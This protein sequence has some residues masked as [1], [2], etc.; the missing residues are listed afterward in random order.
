M[1]YPNNFEEKLGFDRLREWLAS[2]CISLMGDEQAQKMQ[3]ETSLPVIQ[4]KLDLI[5]EFMKLMDNG[6]PFPVRDYSDLREELHHLRIEGTVISQEALFALKPNFNALKAVLRYAVSDAASRYPAFQRLCQGVSLDTELWK[7]CNRLTDDKGEIPDSASPELAAIR[8][9]IRQKL[10]TIDRQMNKLLQEAKN[11]G[12]ADSGVEATIRNGRMVIPVRAADKRKLKGFIHDESATGQ[13]VYI[14]PTAVFDTNNE[15]RELEYAEKREINRILATFT[16]L[17][18][19]YLSDLLA[20]WEL[21]GSIDLVRAK[22]ILAQHTQAGIPEIVDEP[23][24]AWKNARHPLLEKSLNEQQRKIVPLDLVLD[25]ETRILIISGPNAGGKSVC[26]KTAGLIQY[27][28]Q[29]GLAVPMDH[30]AVCGIF[31]KLFID[32]GDEQSLE[33]DLSTYSSHLLN[34][35]QFMAHA[36]AR[37]LFLIDEFGAGTEPQLGGAIAEAVLKTLNDKKAFGL[38]TTHYANLKLMADQQ[39]GVFNGAML[40]DTNKLEPLYMLQTG[41]PGSSFAFE[42]ARKIGFPEE[43][44][45]LAS[46]IT[47]QSHLDFD[48]QLQQLEVEKKALAKKQ[49]EVRLADQLLNEVIEKYKRLLKQVEDNKKNMLAEAGHEAKSLIDKA[50]RQ[51]EHTIKQIR[52]A[53]ADKE[54]TKVLRSQ[55]RD[56]RDLL[57]DEAQELAVKLQQAEE[58]EEEAHQASELKAGDMVRIEEM[59]ISGELLSISEHEAVISFNSVKLRTS[60]ERLVKLSRKDSRKERQQRKAGSSRSITTDLNEKATQFKL[61]N[62]LRGKRAAE[63]LDEVARYIDEAILLS[64]KEVNILHGKGDGILRK[65]IREF[66]SK[67]KEVAFFG[68]APP[69]TGGNGVTKVSLR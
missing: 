1:I 45:A 69:E 3:F 36:D 67:Q 2:Y 22:A 31:D 54:K 63:A 30:D 27:M 60:P 47:G 52:E 51:I 15:V 24:M 12:W 62:D 42:I 48:Q 25:E 11:A 39:E 61:T 50:N 20:G 29:C 57:G 32:I 65:L 46:G 5:E 66:L 8:R 26:L 16:G 17:M 14:E 19:P 41:K 43:I 59:D 4:E 56:T 38:V 6:L 21:L 55:L 37:S 53:Q 35:K 33:N 23:R 68:D 49:T 64:V 18:R 10:G 9:Q 28:L 7:E 58:K 40:F 34:M 44:L 13:T